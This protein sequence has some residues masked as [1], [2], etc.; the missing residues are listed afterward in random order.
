MH[1]TTS[2]EPME[3]TMRRQLRNLISVAV[4]PTFALALGCGEGDGGPPPMKHAQELRADVER[5]APTASDADLAE[6]VSDHTSFALW[7]YG[8]GVETTGANENFLFSPLSISTAFS[9]LWP[10]AVGDTADEIADMLHLRMH[11]D[12]AH[13]AGNRLD[14]ALAS[15]NDYE[16]RENE[17]DAPILEI[18]NDLWGLQDYPYVD[19]FLELLARHYGAGMWIVDFIGAPEAA[20]QEI[21]DY[22]AYKTHQLIPELLPQNSITS[23]TRLVLTN[24]IYFKGAWRFPFEEDATS[25]APF[26]ALDG[27]VSDVPM[28][29]AHIDYAGYA[30]VEGARV[31]DLSY[32]GNDL[33]MMLI[34]P[35]EG[36]FEEFEAG[37]DVA[38]L[39]EIVDSLEYTEGLLVMPRFEFESELELVDIFQKA[40]F[41]LPFAPG[42][43]DFTGL[44]HVALEEELHVTGAFHKAAIAV[45]EEGTE[46]AAATA[47]VVGIESAPALSFDVRLDQP[48]MFVIHDR[49][50]GSILFM[51][52]IVDAAAAQ[53]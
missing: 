36:T 20:R 3:D 12:A 13:P 6:L 41:S 19:E 28:M 9:M 47:I 32:V 14:Q 42:L 46:A 21:N 25:D 11:P 29:S 35:E 31:L 34:L 1:D 45:D 7:M 39:Q 51:G 49:P 4:V 52:R 5:E 8:Q 37:L 17:G 18:V 27:T 33:A 23:L 53:G 48:F 22:I 26:T 50:T 40:G 43:A 44:S 16:P 15:R 38:G 30:E 10:G 2:L 24:A